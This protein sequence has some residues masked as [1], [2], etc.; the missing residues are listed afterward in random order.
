MIADGLSPGRWK[1][2]A[3]A[4]QASQDSISAWAEFR[5]EIDEYRELDS[6]KVTRLVFYFDRDR[7][8][9]DLGLKG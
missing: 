4:T 9:A 8:P 7:A 6:G 1:G 2:V 3:A 5:I